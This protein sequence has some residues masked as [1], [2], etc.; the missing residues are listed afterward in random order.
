MHKD[1][2]RRYQSVEQLSV[3]I[4]RYLDGLPILARPDTFIY[5]SAKFVSRHKVEV[6]AV[7]GVFLA[8]IG[9]VVVSAWE[10]ARADTEAATARAVSDFLQNDLLAQAGANAQARPD[11]KP[12]PLVEALLRPI[13]AGK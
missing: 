13:E 9:G 1:M 4:R 2:A 10:A 3:D 6:A 11:T 12:D 7:V 5:R 8:L